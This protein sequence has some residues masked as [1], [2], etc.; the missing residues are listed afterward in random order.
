MRFF[1]FMTQINKVV[2]EVTMRLS[3]I[4]S[5]IFFFQ[6]HHQLILNLLIRLDL[7]NNKRFMPFSLSTTSSIT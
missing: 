2:W 1:I 3:D 7:S 4:V 5:M 6:Q